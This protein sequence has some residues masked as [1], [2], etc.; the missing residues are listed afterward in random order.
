MKLA[1][2][3]LFA[4]MYIALWYMGGCFMNIDLP[5]DSIHTFRLV[6]VIGFILKYECGT[7]RTSFVKCIL[8]L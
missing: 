3:E 7:S 8:C 5:F 6:S 1:S 4:T 2:R